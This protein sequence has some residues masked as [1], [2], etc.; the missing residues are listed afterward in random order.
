MKGFIAGTAELNEEEEDAFHRR[1][2]AYASQDAQEEIRIFVRENWPR[3]I[4][5]KPDV[6][7]ARRRLQERQERE[8]RQGQSAQPA[9]QHGQAPTINVSHLRGDDLDLDAL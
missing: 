7:I 5:L 9:V 6:I 3:V 1:G 8:E 2:D 4:A